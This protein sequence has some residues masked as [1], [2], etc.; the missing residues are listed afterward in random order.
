M[1]D[2]CLID[3]HT[4]RA[5]AEGV[6]TPRSFGIH[7]WY[8]DKVACDDRDMFFNHYGDNMAHAEIIGEC[9]LDKACSSSWEQQTKLFR[10]Q[11]DY[12]AKLN[13]PMVI[14]CVRA[15]NEVIAVRHKLAS[16]YKNL[17]KWVIHG[18]LGGLQMADQLFRVGIWVSFGEAITDPRR[19]KVRQ[20]LAEIKTPFLLETDDSPVGIERVYQA[21][22]DIRC[23]SMALLMETIDN[24][25]NS[26][27]TNHQPYATKN[28]KPT[29]YL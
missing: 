9:G 15:F 17:A 14:H 7:P 25:Y 8:A 18:Y 13:M 10:W 29:R 11:A 16:F 27:F 28:N 19:I 22:A 6:I 24:H 5:T 21:A 20:C 26:L 3:F 12:A 23:C 4:H 2:Y 1:S